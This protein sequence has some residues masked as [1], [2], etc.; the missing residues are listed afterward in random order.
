MRALGL[1]PFVIL[2]GAPIFA[3]AAE[4]PVVAVFDIE[5]KGVKLPTET[6][7]LL[8]DYLATEIAGSGVYETVPRDEIKQRLQVQ[9]KDSY[10]ACFAQSCQIELGQELAAQKLLS[11]QVMKLGKKCLITSTLYDLRRAIAEHGATADGAC[12]EESVVSLLKEVARKLVRPLDV[13]DPSPATGA[14]SSAGTA[15]PASPASKRE[16]AKKACDD[17]KLASCVEIANDLR[18]AGSDAEAAILYKRACEGDVAAGCASYGWMVKRGAG[19]EKDLKR[20]AMLLDRACTL[21]DLAGCTELALSYETGTGVHQNSH[22]A[23]ELYQ[24]ACDGDYAWGCGGLGWMKKYGR[25]IEVDYDAAGAMLQRACDGGDMGGCAEL[26]GLFQAGLGRV[27]DSKRAV[28][29]YQRSCNGGWA[30]GC[31]GLGWMYK[32]GYGVRVDRARA[33]R[34]LKSG[35]D[36]GDWGACHELASLSDR[37]QA[38]DLLRTACEHGF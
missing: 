10:R 15:S 19:V 8:S 5:N 32:Y 36:Q 37:E 25:G 17:G 1:S 27:Q 16:Q 33:T 29:L 7:A 14:S 18:K 13:F 2:F 38:Q 23:I 30:Y 12:D 34:L 28:D 20:S 3:S 26:A 22:R 21:G 24:K 6:L 11:T 35:C 31:G 4:R 9:K